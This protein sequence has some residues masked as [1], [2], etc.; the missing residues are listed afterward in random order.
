[1]GGL[2]EEGMKQGESFVYGLLLRAFLRSHANQVRLGEDVQFTHQIE[3]G[4]TV[5]TGEGI[6]VG[7][8]WHDTETIGLNGTI[9]YIGRGD[10][11]Y[12]P[13]ARKRAIVKYTEV[14]L[15]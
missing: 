8:S 5:Y 6:K 7:K 4:S 12:N 11:G 2:T 1:M 3:Q 14:N 15:G 13:N 9:L 10:G